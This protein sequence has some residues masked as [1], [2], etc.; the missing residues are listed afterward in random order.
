[1]VFPHFLLYL[2]NNKVLS[3][4]NVHD[5][6]SKVAFKRGERKLSL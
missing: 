2:E 1:M 5:K 3:S 4:I 6:H